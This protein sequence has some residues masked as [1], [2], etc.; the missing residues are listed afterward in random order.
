MALKVE[1]N[2]PNYPQ[3]EPVGIVGVGVIENGGSIDIGEDEE[4]AFFM[5]NG[6]TLVDAGQEGVD[7]S[8]GSE[9]TPPE[10]VEDQQPTQPTTEQEQPT[11]PDTGLP[12][13]LPQPTEGGG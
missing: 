10:P 7:V 9:F 6:Y 11:V 4:S 3:G 2:L 5:T 1:V 8:G 12:T 13:G